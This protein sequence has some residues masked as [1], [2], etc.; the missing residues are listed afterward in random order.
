MTLIAIIVTD[1]ANK[2]H[3]FDEI[4]GEIEHYFEYNR[5]TPNLC[6]IVTREF[7][8]K[9]IF[10]SETISLFY[11]PLRVTSIFEEDE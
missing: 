10:D 11:S 5:E 7:T 9:P 6:R 3:R 2:E 1:A 4:P 8:T